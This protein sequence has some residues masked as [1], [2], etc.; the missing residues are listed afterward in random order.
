MTDKGQSHREEVKEFGRFGLLRFEGERVGGGLRVMLYGI[1]GID[2]L[3]DSRVG[4]MSHGGRI[5]I[6]GGNLKVLV[7]EGNS[8]EIV[9]RVK[10]IDFKYGRD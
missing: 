8:V 9:G 3:S 10:E 1:I 7:Y 6:L 4:L 5:R 2:E